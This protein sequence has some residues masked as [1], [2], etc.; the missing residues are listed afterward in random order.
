[1]THRPL[2]SAVIPTRAR[3]ALVV[4]AVRTALN[5]TYA[6]LEV[7][8]VID[9]PDEETMLALSGLQQPRLRVITLPQSAGGAS[10]RNAGV[11]AAHGEWIAFLDDDDEWLP[12]KIEN[13]LAAAQG[14]GNSEPIVSCRFTAQTNTGEHVWPLRLP[15]DGE[16]ISDYLLVRNGVERTEGFIATPTILARRSLLRRVPFTDG[17]KRHQDWDWV[18]RATREPGVRVVFCPQALVICNMRS[19]NSVSRKSDWR[20]S[21]EWIHKMAPVI[22]KRAHASFLTCHVAWQAAAERDWQAFFPLLMEA[23]AGG[24]LRMSDVA[25]YAGFWFTPQS[26]R[27]WARSQKARTQ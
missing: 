10:A 12:A 26:L 13:Q 18:L 3:A 24:G 22:S 2:V 27:Q 5:Q 8:V 25:R 23:A 14:S 17:L 21:Q 4:R 19:A 6:N 1:M 7:I 9:G 15:E 20:F 16:S 11:E